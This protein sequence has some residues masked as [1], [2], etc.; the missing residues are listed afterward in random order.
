MRAAEPAGGHAG[1]AP[2]RLRLA[3]EQTHQGAVDVRHRGA[4]RAGPA[5]ARFRA[6]GDHQF[7]SVRTRA[8]REESFRFGPD[9]GTIEPGLEGQ[10]QPRFAAQGRGFVVAGLRI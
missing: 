5:P 1:Q 3:P 8:P 7:K 9:T 10:E 6:F 2:F 4:G